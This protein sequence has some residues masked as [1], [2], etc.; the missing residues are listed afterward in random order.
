MTRS[1]GPRRAPNLSDAVQQRPNV[2]ALAASAAVPM[3]PKPQGFFV[4]T[5]SSP[6]VVRGFLYVD[7][8]SAMSPP[9][10]ATVTATQ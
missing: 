10:M 6:W 8:E 1:S 7:E 3:T 4:G 9:I 2:D 5:K